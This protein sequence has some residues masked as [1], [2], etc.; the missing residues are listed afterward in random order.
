MLRILIVEDSPE[1]QKVLCDL[2]REHA[3]VLVHTARRAV[4]LLSAFDF[5]L[6]FL[7]YDLAGEDNGEAVARRLAAAPH[8][9]RVI[10]HSQNRPGA[11]RILQLLPE[12]RWLPIASITRSNAVFKRLREALRRG[13]DFDWEQVA[14]HKD[15]AGN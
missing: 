10:I 13:V 8:R 5:D 2:A 9:P 11:E 14:A 15:R 4:T 1:R 7:D 3:W 12:A 6:V